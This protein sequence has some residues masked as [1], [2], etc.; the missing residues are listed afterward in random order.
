MSCKADLHRELHRE[1]IGALSDI[2]G[3]A[4]VLHE[5]GGNATIYLGSQLE[6][7]FNRADQALANLT[8]IPG[9][10]NLTE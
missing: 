10:A 2:R 8:G 6:D 9:V 3:V 5:I 7:H 1:L 4:F